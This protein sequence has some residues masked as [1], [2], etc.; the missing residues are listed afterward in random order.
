MRIIIII[1]L[2]HQEED[3]SGDHDV[4]GDHEWAKR[5]RS[6]R[7]MMRAKD[8]GEIRHV[9]MILF[10]VLFQIYITWF[11]DIE[12]SQTRTD[13]EDTSRSLAPTWMDGNPFGPC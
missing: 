9:L 13:K 2:N 10:K 3:E 8:S 7:E 12:D 5:N 4:V 6:T 11:E 1:S